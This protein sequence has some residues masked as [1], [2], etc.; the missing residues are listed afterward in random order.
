MITNYV[1]YDNYSICI[2]MKKFQKKIRPTLRILTSLKIS[3][4]VTSDK[5][6]FFHTQV[7]I[8]VIHKLTC[9]SWMYITSQYMG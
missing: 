9:H 8:E 4:V 6:R 7:L 5:L 1:K 3:R 2:N